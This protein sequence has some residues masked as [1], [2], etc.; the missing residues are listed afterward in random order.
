MTE[1]APTRTATA[2]DALAEEYLAAEAELDPI[3]ATNIG[4]TGYDAMMPDLSPDGLA[5]RAALTRHT[6]AKLASAQP[7]DDTDLVTIAAMRERLEVSREL[8][9]RGDR[10]AE[11][12]N[13]ASPVQTLRAVFDL[14]PTETV[15][16]WGTVAQRLSAIPAAIEGY[17]QSLRLAAQRGDVAP[18][19]QVRAGITQSEANLGEN[20]F[21]SRFVE[22]AG[23]SVPGTLRA[24]LDRA[25]HAAQAGYQRLRDFLAEELLAQAPQADA[26]GRDRYPA[27]ARLFLGA[28]IDLDDTYAWGQQEL[29]RI[30][31]L[32]S[33]TANQIKAGASVTEAIEVLEADPGR[34]L[35]STD[36]LRAWMQ[37]RADEAIENL[38]GT[39]FDIPGP[40]RKLECMIAPTTTGVIYYTNPSDDFSRP[41]RMWWSVPAGVTE[42]STWRELT[43]VYHEG[44]PGHHLQ[45]AQSVYNKAQL[46]S[47]RRM[48]SW[49]SG[50]GE[51]WALYSEW[52]MADLG[53]M[54]DPGNRLGLLAGQSLR[55]A[56]V[57]ID[58][59]LHCGFAA[60]AEVGGG[61]WT[62][63]KAW[64]LLTRHAFMEPEFLRFELERYLGWPGQAPSYKLGEKLWLE[65]RDQA[66]TQAGPSFDL[67][68]FHRDALNLG[69]VGLDVLRRAVLRQL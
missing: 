52:L 40:V 28:D 50:H 69:S 42:F 36:A 39:H 7:D 27:L 58:V 35:P 11:L 47:W 51:G 31:K 34:R 49:T 54:D 45:I 22:R 10:L 37:E 29:A 33:E 46:N 2:V 55:A 38:G 26:V 6:L 48:G 32:M 5:Q 9:E 15:E 12:N 41:G 16:D 30:A 57:V 62:Y 68:A 61:D 63:D 14:M 3:G 24:D 44:V 20:G 53:Y 17:L 18:A 66:R 1:S 25:S 65:L 56:R 23:D 19:R 59:G 21:F 64:T 43:T 4:L 60:P 67:K 8:D 13:I